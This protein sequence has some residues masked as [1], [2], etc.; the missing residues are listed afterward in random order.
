MDWACL[1]KRASDGGK[2][3]EQIEKS[4]GDGVKTAAHAPTLYR[5]PN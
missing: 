4:V 5:I 2:D 1:D 3:R